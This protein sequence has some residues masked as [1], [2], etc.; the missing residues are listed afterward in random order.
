VHKHAPVQ[1][2]PTTAAL[3]AAN[4]LLYAGVYTPLKQ[5]SVVNTWW[6]VLL[7]PDAASVLRS[8]SVAVYHKLL[9]E[10]WWL[11][12]LRWKVLSVLGTM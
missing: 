9:P 7:G 1:T 10:S 8:W 3:G 5:L 4:I 11:L 6:V 2:N 12:L